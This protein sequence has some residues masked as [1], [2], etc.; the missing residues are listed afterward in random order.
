MGKTKYTYNRN[1]ADGQLWVQNH[2]LPSSPDQLIPFYLNGK[3]VIVTSQGNPVH[4]L[5]KTSGRI[6]GDFLV[7]RRIVEADELSPKV[8][9]ATITQPS[10]A[11]KRYR[12]KFAAVGQLGVNS[13]PS[14]L[15]SS[16]AD[17][18]AFGTTAI[19][20]V[21]PNNPIGG[22]SVFLGELKREGLPSLPGIHSWKGR[23]DIARSAGS[24]YL[25]QEFGWEPLISDIR[26]FWYAAHQSE[27][28]IEQY[29]RGSGKRIHR[30]YRAPTVRETLSD[31]LYQDYTNTVAPVLDVSFWASTPK[32]R[33]I[34][35]KI[36]DRWFEGCFT[37]YLPPLDPSGGNGQR[38]RQIARKLYG[39]E[40]TPETVWNL[41]PW[42][43][44][45]DWMTNAGDVFHNIS[46]F[47]NDGLVMHY[48][49]V[50]EQIVH[51]EEHYL[52]NV[53]TKSQPTVERTATTIL[54]TTTKRRKVATPYGFGLDPLGFT[55]RQLSIL[56]ALGIAKS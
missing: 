15:T 11:W 35:S 44:A 5:G 38:N 21:L 27:R 45:I 31:T 28:I 4:K 52:Y 33:V 18:N 40:V 48:G 29:A 19:A 41:T 43:W 10:S 30:S 8:Y 37:Y 51:R 14:A 53:K 56:G 46:G 26:K 12:G 3:D 1:E 9:A 55:S 13:W 39:A 23:T 24:E 32:K 49:Y 54:S 25:N 50:M 47:A 20:N 16:V 22:L 7:E 36:T 34:K 2:N 42:S 6:G 17:L